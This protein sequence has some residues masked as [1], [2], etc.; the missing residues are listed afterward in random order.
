MNGVTDFQL[1]FT[2]DYQLLA[3][4]IIQQLRRNLSQ[5]ELSDKLGYSFNQVGKWESGATQIKWDDF[6]LLCQIQEVPLE[7]A[8]RDCFWTPS[9]EFNVAITLKA[10]EDTFS[11]GHH[12]DD[13]F[14]T[15][16]KKWA[17]G[18]YTPDL[19]EVLR[20][21]GTVPTALIGWLSLFVDCEKLQALSA[22]YKRLPVVINTLFERP[23]AAFVY[24]ALQLEAYQSLSFHGETLLAEH[25]ACTRSELRTTLEHL[26]ANGLIRFDGRK[27]YPLSIGMDI[28]WLS[29]PKYK[30][31][32]QHATLHAARRFTANPNLRPPN[33]NNNISYA[34]ERT[35]CLSTQA[36]LEISK[37]VLRFHNEAEEIIS[38]DAHPKTNVQIILSHAFLPVASAHKSSGQPAAKEKSHP[39][40]IGTSAPPSL[41]EFA[42][43]PEVKIDFATTSRQILQAMR[44][45][46]SQRQLSD[47]L[48]FTFN[49]VGKW[50]SGA[51]QLK[52][53]DFLRICK[54][55]GISIENSFWHGYLT[56]EPE[57][58]PLSTLRILSHY[59]AA[60]TS[61]NKQMHKSMERWLSGK[62][63]PDFAEVLKF[64]SN[65]MALML[66][67]LSEIV[68]CSKIP[69]LS[70][71]ND[72]YLARSQ[73]TFKASDAMLIYSALY[74]DA[75]QQLEHHSEEL[76]AELTACSPPLIRQV[77]HSINLNGFVHFDGNKYIP[78]PH[79]E[80]H[81]RNWDAVCRSTQRAA[82]TYS[83]QSLSLGQNPDLGLDF[84]VSRA[85]VIALSA[86]GSRL[87]RNL[88]W[89]YQ[90]ELGE[91]IKRDKFPK[92]H[93]M[94]VILHSYRSNTNAPDDPDNEAY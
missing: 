49:Q 45:E 66:T 76:L 65:R 61:L 94:T 83:T 57:L 50:E 18:K 20:L 26:L 21:I 82:L 28:S 48:G 84:S 77:L 52:W 51:T 93:L 59:F 73:A 42:Q 71:A 32:T 13:S 70:E 56:P 17:C 88:I 9:S 39:N 79:S 46:L 22:P 44:G 33:L 7:K 89:R 6:I 86:P 55:L 27:F 14:Q 1:N 80:A 85:R 40:T 15:V 23:V 24:A 3:R 91:I 2:V 54:T 47:K 37:R 62:A 63:V 29:H 35:A 90:T 43:E 10:L 69:S 58:T 92:Q 75:Y 34:S 36:V 38:K 12:A 8:F 53:D 72:F 60:G 19:A 30:P 41:M 67:W 16:F 4:E 81:S 25:S 31:V 64:M 78:L 68:D 11:T 5:R 74:L 87:I